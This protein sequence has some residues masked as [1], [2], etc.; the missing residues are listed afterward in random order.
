MH[1]YIVI[2]GHG[3]LPNIPVDH[4]K[5]FVIQLKTIKSFNPWRTQFN[6]A[7]SYSVVLELRFRAV[8][9]T[10]SCIQECRRKS[11]FYEER[12]RCLHMYDADGNQYIDY[13]A[14]WGPMILGH[15]HRVV[16][17]IRQR[18]ERGHFIW[19]TD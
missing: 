8:K 3:I 1:K 17:A 14:S 11:D 9:L 4:A 19:R 5:A 10:C 18:G 6:I 2:S 15:G 7:K 12:Q 16:E 13:I